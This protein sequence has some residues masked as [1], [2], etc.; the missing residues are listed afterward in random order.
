MKS[1]GNPE[2]K[3][4]LVKR[5]QRVQPSSKRRWGK[6]SPHQMI[7]HLADGYRLYTG[8]ISAEPVPGP[9]VVKA[10]VRKA[11]LYLPLSWP[12]G[13]IPTLPEIDQVAGGGTCPAE[14]ANDVQALCRLLNQFTQLPKDFVFRPHPGLGSMSYAQWMRPGYLH[15]DH[16]LRQ[17]GA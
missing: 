5:I 7:C 1:L 8:E 11:A 17:I 2:H 15:A 12:K 14:F 4:E 6:M 16:H 3:Q 9:A 10:I 13:R